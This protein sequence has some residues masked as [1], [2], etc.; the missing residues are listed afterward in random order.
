[1]SGALA[2]AA[3]GGCLVAG[4]RQRPSLAGCRL[5]GTRQAGNC[6]AGVSAL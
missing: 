5:A 4:R 2:E 1:M 3:T 6:A